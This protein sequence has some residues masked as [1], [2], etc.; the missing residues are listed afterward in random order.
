MY[1]V[2]KYA[3][4]SVNEVTKRINYAAYISQEAYHIVYCRIR[5]EHDIRFPK[6]ML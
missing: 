6:G 1:F 4:F 3:T 5:Y 2:V